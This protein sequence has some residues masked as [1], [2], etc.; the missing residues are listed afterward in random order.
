[1][2]IDPPKADRIKEF[3]LYYLLKRAGRSD[4]HNSFRRRR[5]NHHSSFHEVS[6]KA[7]EVRDPDTW[8][9]TPS[10]SYQNHPCLRTTNKE[11]KVDN[12]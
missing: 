10:V 6:Y 1:M 11:L 5:I 2:S 9:L 12:K 7:V 3:F 8:T 4:I